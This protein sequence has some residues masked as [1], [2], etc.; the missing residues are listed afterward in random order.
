MDFF[1]SEGKEALKAW[2]HWAH[3]D[4]PN[5]GFPSRSV[6]VAGANEESVRVTHSHAECELVDKFLCLYRGA[7]PLE[8]QIARR[9]YLKRE[10]MP[11]I[12]E[13]LECGPKSCRWGWSKLQSVEKAVGQ[14][15]MF[16][17]SL[18]GVD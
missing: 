12:V 7:S 3:Y 2:A 15:L 1:V 14:I 6:G 11:L 8:Y 4:H 9:A 10:P 18:A 5:V 17:A 13:T 16:H